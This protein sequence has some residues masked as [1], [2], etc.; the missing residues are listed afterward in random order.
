MQLNSSAQTEDVV[1]EQRYGAGSVKSAVPGTTARAWTLE[2][3][4][5]SH[6]QFGNGTRLGDGRV[7]EWSR[8]GMGLPSASILP[9]PPSR[10]MELA[11]GTDSALHGCIDLDVRS[12]KDSWT[13]FP[14]PEAAAV[15]SCGYRQ[16]SRQ[17]SV[18][19]WDTRGVD[20]DRQS[21]L[22]DIEVTDR[23][24]RG[25]DRSHVPQM[26][27]RWNPRDPFE[28]GFWIPK[29]GE[30]LENRIAHPNDP[31][32]LMARTTCP[33]PSLTSP[34]S[35]RFHQKTRIQKSTRRSL[36]AEERTRHVVGF[37][38]IRGGTCW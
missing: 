21:A 30:Q 16:P 23:Q 31:P 22:A 35:S 28:E 33:H 37:P 13:Q 18:H 8:F 20:Q 14:R 1:I 6:F 26:A 29:P 12:Q 32:T 17:R 5:R 11:G 2:D 38:C 19:Y 9:M 10:C 36:S 15:P 27:E 25:L 24:L 4:S 3:S 34:C 7:E